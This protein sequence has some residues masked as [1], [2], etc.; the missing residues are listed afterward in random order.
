MSMNM[1][2]YKR[3]LT[4]QDISCLGQCSGS[5]ALPV[6]SACGHET[7]LIP[8]ALL[9]T[10]TGQFQGYTFFDLTEQIPGIIDH[11][12]REGIMF[13]AL[14]TGYLGSARQAQFAREMIDTLL[15]PAAHIVVDPAMADNGKLYAGLD[16]ACVKAMRCLCSA[17]DVI[18]P[19]LTEA[20]LLTGMEY[21]EDWDGDYVARLLDALLETGAKSVVL[22]GVVFSSDAT[23]GI[24]A[25]GTERKYFRHRRVNRM[26]HGTGDVF[27]AAFTG[28]FLRGLSLEDAAELAARFTLRSIENTEDDPAHWYGV[29]FET[30]LPLLI[31]ELGEHE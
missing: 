18:L 10:H 14:Y 28:A 6:L 23:G 12:R 2:D 8:S 27:A 15:R 21:R 19:N 22:T 26:F 7:C 16:D 17:A 24:I 20:C 31:K 1:Q 9:S 25:H 3:I 5:V 30:A 11:W 4:M 13:D 29:K